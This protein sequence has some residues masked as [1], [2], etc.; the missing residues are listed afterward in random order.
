MVKRTSAPTF[1][2]TANESF[3][4]RTWM[5]RAEETSIFTR[6][7]LM[8]QAWNVLLST[9]HSTGF[10]CFHLTARS[11]C[12]LPIATQKRQ[13][14]PTCSLLIGWNNVHHQ[15]LPQRRKVMQALLL[16]A[17]APLRE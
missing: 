10:R 13:A 9:K 17:F 15:F 3:S 12:L 6:S 5:T 8:V 4:P 7:M 2:L 1:S 11:L 16:C 14:K